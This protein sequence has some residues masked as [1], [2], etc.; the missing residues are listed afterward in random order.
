MTTCLALSLTFFGFS[1]AQIKLNGEVVTSVKHGVN[2]LTVKVPLRAEDKKYDRLAIVVNVMSESG[3]AGRQQ[4]NLGSGG[5]QRTLRDHFAQGTYF[6]DFQSESKFQKLSSISGTIIKKD[7]KSSFNSWLPTIDGLSGGMDNH[8]LEM[9]EID[10]HPLRVDK[11]YVIT[12]ELWG[13]NAEKKWDKNEATY[14]YEYAYKELKVFDTKLKYEFAEGHT[15]HYAKDKS[16]SVS[17]IVKGSFG[18]PN[19][20]SLKLEKE[21]KP[22][23]KV[24]SQQNYFTNAQE[25]GGIEAVNWEIY[26]S[27]TFYHFSYDFIS[28]PSATMSFEDTKT[29]LYNYMFVLANP[30]SASSNGFGGGKM[31]GK[32]IGAIKGKLNKDKS[33]DGEG[34]NGDSKAGG[35]PASVYWH[36]YIDCY[37]VIPGFCQNLEKG[38]EAN[39]KITAAYPEVP[40]WEKTEIE[41]LDEAFILKSSNVID[42][43]HGFQLD[44]STK[45]YHFDDNCENELYQWHMFVGKKGD[46]VFVGAYAAKKQDD[47]TNTKNASIA[48]DLTKTFKAL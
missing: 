28:F 16:F 8:D 11:N 27:E 19:C 21:A 38:K 1:Q 6:Q 17:K 34:S 41:G 14:Y 26:D 9:N 3:F 31:L 24:N 39:D 37:Y 29:D 47:A 5:V 13:A 25:S 44:F 18:N 32:G 33:D 30:A 43:R 10:I 15:E 48:T 42:Y 36:K 2:N 23:T 20:Q 7:G 35:G 46:K 12:V 40:S 45:K 4:I 22:I